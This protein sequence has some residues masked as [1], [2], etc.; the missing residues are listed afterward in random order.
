MIMA[1]KIS[2]RRGNWKEMSDGELAGYLEECALLYMAKHR[3][4]F[5]PDC[6]IIHRVDYKAHGIPSKAL[7]AMWA[8]GPWLEDL[9]NNDEL[10]MAMYNMDCELDLIY[11][12]AFAVRF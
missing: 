11:G 3:R 5:G 4:D 12:K 6:G 7:F 2:K 10:S 9:R 8:D 1:T